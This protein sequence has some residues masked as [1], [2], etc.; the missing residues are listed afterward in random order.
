MSSLTR[1]DLTWLE[2]AGEEYR[3]EQSRTALRD[4]F[5]AAAEAVRCVMAHDAAG[6]AMA[7][8]E[9]SR[10]ADEAYEHGSLGAESFAHVLAGI[11]DGEES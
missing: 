4:A 10:A 6:T 9:A 11:G 5:L 8:L 2:N 3:I 7:V 1:L